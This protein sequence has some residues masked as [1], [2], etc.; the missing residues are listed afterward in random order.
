MHA[1]AETP[2][3]FVQCSLNKPEQVLPAAGK[4]LDLDVIVHGTVMADGGAWRYRRDDKRCTRE[5]DL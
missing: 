2:E 1:V 3:Q 5:K 4:R